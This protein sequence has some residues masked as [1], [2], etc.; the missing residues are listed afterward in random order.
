MKTAVDKVV[1]RTNGRV[2]N[3]RFYAMTTH[4]LFEPEFCNA[5][6]GWEKG[7]VKKNVQDSRRSVW[8]EAKTQSFNSFEELNTWLDQRCR[9]LW[10]ELEHPNYAGI[11]LAAALEEE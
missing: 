2:V 3:S 5:A 8:I 9:A 6:S 11:T 10:S 7:I 1:K 4:Y